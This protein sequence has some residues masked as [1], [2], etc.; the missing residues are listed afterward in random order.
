MVGKGIDV[1]TH[2]A[3]DQLSGEAVMEG[4]QTTL[5]SR[6]APRCNQVNRSGELSG[7]FDG[8]S[9]RGEGGGSW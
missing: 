4:G 3:L 6:M 7:H 2:W 8:L 1:G 9:V 5:T